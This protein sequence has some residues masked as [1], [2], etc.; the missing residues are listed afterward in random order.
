MLDTYNPNHFISISTARTFNLKIYIKT[1]P[2]HIFTLGI[3][4]LIKAPFNP[5]LQINRRSRL[6][7]DLDIYDARVSSSD[8]ICKRHWF[9]TVNSFKPFLLAFVY[10]KC[11][12]HW[13]LFQLKSS[14]SRNLK[15]KNKKK[16]SLIKD[17]NFHRENRYLLIWIKR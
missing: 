9:T 2:L 16:R 5:R 4:L 17:L 6:C 14:I 12:L 3:P 8:F 1:K 13:R 7:G 10:M 11:N 15:A